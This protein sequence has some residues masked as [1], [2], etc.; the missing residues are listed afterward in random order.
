MPKRVGSG[1]G[2]NVVPIPR[3]EI[4]HAQANTKSN[5]EA[6]R[7]LGVSYKRYKRYATIYGL[8]DKHMN[9]R[10]FGTQKGYAAKASS[11]SLKDIFANK[12]KGYSLVRLKHRMIARGLIA[13][14]CA[15]CGFKEKRITD[16]KTPLL[17]TF[18]N[19]EKD[20]TQDNL[21]LLCY[22]C[23]FLTVGAPTVANRGYIEKSLKDPDSIPKEWQVNPRPADML[24]PADDEPDD[25]ADGFE[26]I[27]EEI[28]R[29]L[30]RD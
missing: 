13:E 3:A 28:L 16:S 26:D 5:M 18:K 14:E 30:G 11:I 20:F 7:F 23:L 1:R 10:G 8:F 29:E 9:P 27:R 17:L 25:N 24:D 6:A 19:G 4:E 21:E 12:H 22:N 2:P 15:M